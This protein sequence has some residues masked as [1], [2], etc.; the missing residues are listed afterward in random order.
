MLLFFKPKHKI[1]LL[2]A[3]MLEYSYKK[4]RSSES[5]QVIPRQEKRTKERGFANFERKSSFF[6][7]LPAKLIAMSIIPRKRSRPVPPARK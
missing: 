2:S 6:K 7:N 1:G 4:I 3:V 5:P